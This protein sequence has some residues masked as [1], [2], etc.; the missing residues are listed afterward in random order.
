MPLFRPPI[1]LVRRDALHA[2]TLRAIP[3]ADTSWTSDRGH[4]MRA[5]PNACLMLYRGN[6]RSSNHRGGR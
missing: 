2:R 5:C 1:R 3:D 4:H 6:E